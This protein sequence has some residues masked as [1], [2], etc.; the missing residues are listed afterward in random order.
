MTGAQSRVDRASSK[1]Q[2]GR[3]RRPEAVTVLAAER[4]RSVIIGLP[5]PAPADALSL[6]L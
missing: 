2:A 5:G 3:T 4:L 6:T 1:V